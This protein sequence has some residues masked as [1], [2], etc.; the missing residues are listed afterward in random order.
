MEHIQESAILIYVVCDDLLRSLG[1]RDDPQVRMSTAE[2]LC[3]SILAA[4]HFQGN[5][6]KARLWLGGK[7]GL[8]P[9]IL[10][11]SQLNRRF[12]AVP[13]EVWWLIFHMLAELFRER[14]G[15]G[16][17]VVD[18]FPV[19]CCTRN[20]IDMKKLFPG[21]DYLSYASSLKSYFCGVKVHM[22]VSNEGAPIEFR[23]QPASCADIT[24]LWTMNL[25]LPKGALLYGD[26]AYQSEE[27]RQILMEDQSLHLVAL[28]P[29]KKTKGEAQKAIRRLISSDRQ[30]VERSFSAICR[31]FPR[32]FHI[33]TEKGL[34]LRLMS[35]ILAYSFSFYTSILG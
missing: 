21:N 22:I 28:S 19:L 27:L 17:Y 12:H 14:S 33:R 26:S 30:V 24:T 32:N 13:S 18:S 34:L 29:Y 20:R 9:T 2:V 4:D 23:I 31:R 8:F 15:P 11:K 7:R 35:A 6:S 10:S 1:Y 5:H 25:H 3:F 16:P